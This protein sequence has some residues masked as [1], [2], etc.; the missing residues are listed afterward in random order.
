MIQNHDI[1]KSGMCLFSKSSFL[2]WL[3]KATARQVNLILVY[4]NLKISSLFTLKGKTNKRNF[5]VV[6]NFS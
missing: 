2:I 3:K 6:S 1:I 5:F 4:M